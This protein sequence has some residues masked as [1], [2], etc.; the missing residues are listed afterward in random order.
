[1]T[2]RFWIYFGLTCLIGSI[3]A[4]A[5]TA[6]QL[7]T[8]CSIQNVLA[9]HS[10]LTLE[11][12]T[13]NCGKGAEP[14]TALKVQYYWL[15]ATSAT[16]LL[17][18]RSNSRLTSLLGDR[19]VVITNDVTASFDD[20]RKRFGS[21]V[22]SHSQFSE[23]YSYVETYVKGIQGLAKS[24]RQ[25]LDRLRSTDFAGLKFFDGTGLLYWPDAAAAR[26]MLS[27]PLFP[28]GYRH[29]VGT[30]SSH[31]KSLLEKPEI[32]E[33]DLTDIMNALLLSRIFYKPLGM[34]DLL[35]YDTRLIEMQRLAFSGKAIP[36]PSWGDLRDL[37]PPLPKW[38]GENTAEIEAETA[39]RLPEL[40]R[41]RTLSALKYIGRDGLPSDF[42][43]AY[44]S[45]GAHG[46][47]EPIWSLF[48]LPRKPFLQI[49]VIE[50]AA[51]TP[52]DYSLSQIIT[53]RS[54]ATS[55]R[56]PSDDSQVEQQ[57]LPFVPGR[58]SH[59]ERVVIPL[60]LEFRKPEAL[61]ENEYSLPEPD[62]DSFRIVTDAVH[63]IPYGD[64]TGRHLGN[65]SSG[66]Y[67]PKTKSQ[68]LT[69]QPPPP[70]ERSYLYG[71]SYRIE[72]V[73]LDDMKIPIRPAKP[74]GV[75]MVAG[76][77]GGSCPILYYR[78]KSSDEW[79]KIG[80]ILRT[81][82]GLGR[83]TTER[84]SLPSDVSEI[85][86]VEEELERSIIKRLRIAAE[87]RSGRE[88]E[89]AMIGEPFHL[90]TGQVRTLSIPTRQTGENPVLEIEGYFVSYSSMISAAGTD[91]TGVELN[92]VTPSA[93]YRDGTNGS[94]HT[95][96][97]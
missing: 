27:T 68:F 96:R 97:P 24:E 83:Q 44:G 81:S 95:M 8:T 75:Y 87:D 36:K 40:G 9:P 11:N 41:S 26:Q 50:N 92:S 1:M 79:I 74:A 69:N 23:S 31:V 21:T 53:S 10:N 57:S 73:V 43:F 15:D 18:G 12:V 60:A 84:Y 93:R 63:Q 64:V 30:I 28:A 89:L 59:K 7:S 13:I 38:T 47:E 16:L 52:T 85:A 67:S 54:S 17:A 62:E 80:S 66:T 77:E 48:A 51:S 33:G 91:G 88:I 46:D 61:S 35:S 58:L 37:Q 94:R 42:L 72:Y 78:T 20:L 34:A 22:S 19:P 82:H 32:D 3:S 56:L 5:Q 45:Y 6:F 25:D 29:Y 86:L 71:P 90:D 2:L 55:L 49:A 14:K 4:H 39:R 76:Y 70:I 65:I